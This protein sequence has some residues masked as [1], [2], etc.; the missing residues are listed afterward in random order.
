[1]LVDVCALVRRCLFACDM[2]CLP[3]VVADVCMFPVCVSL[4]VCVCVLTWSVKLTS[5]SSAGAEDVKFGSV[6]KGERR[7]GKLCVLTSVSFG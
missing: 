2:P 3:A 1:M 7:G 4:T 5:Q 6:Q